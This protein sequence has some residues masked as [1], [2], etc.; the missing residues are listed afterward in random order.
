MSNFLLLNDIFKMKII[1]VI[2]YLVKRLQN[3]LL[4]KGL[5]EFVITDT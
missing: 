3:I 5:L 1:I 2:I 4:K